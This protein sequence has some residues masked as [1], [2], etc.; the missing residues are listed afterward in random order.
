MAVWIASVIHN[1]RADPVRVRKPVNPLSFLLGVAFGA[2]AA[3]PLYVPHVFVNNP[4]KILVLAGLPVGIT[5]IAGVPAG[6]FASILFCF[7]SIKEGTTGGMLL[8]QIAATCLA[9]GWGL[10]FSKASK[11]LGALGVLF[12]N[13]ENASLGSGSSIG[14]FRTLYE[15][16]FLERTLL[17][18]ILV[19]LAVELGY[20]DSYLWRKIKRILLKLRRGAYPTTPELVA[21]LKSDP[22][23]D[24][25]TYRFR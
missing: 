1:L 16:Q 2:I 22:G 17:Q 11:P 15:G 6:V 20:R 21:T 18:T 3:A 24:R 13:I 8:W 19:L 9:C 10:A 23:K 4:G 5:V 14:W 12:M 7:I 25:H